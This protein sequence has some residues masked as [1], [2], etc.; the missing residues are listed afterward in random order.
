MIIKPSA[1]AFKSLLSKNISSKSIL[2]LP[3]AYE[4]YVR[5]ASNAIGLISL[6]GLNTPLPI[7]RVA[8]TGFKRPSISKE[9]LSAPEI[10]ASRTLNHPNSR[11]CNAIS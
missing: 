3:G 10:G 2:P 7:C 11:D 4:K 9:P 6:D 1:V 5:A 8:F